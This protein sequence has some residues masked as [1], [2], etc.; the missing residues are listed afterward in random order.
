MVIKL[1]LAAVLS[2]GLIAPAGADLQDGVA[3]YVRGDFATAIREWKPLAE[4]GDPEAQFHLGEM[5]LRGRGVTQNFQE[6]ADWYTK[7]A[8]SGHSGAQ[9]VLGGLHAVGLGVPQD[10]GEAYFWLIV[11][12]IWSKSEIRQQAMTSLG[13]VAKQLTPAEKAGIARQAIA[14]WRK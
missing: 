14:Q 5:Y 12:A 11:A 6:A 8:E 10:F 2:L 1:T 4:Q 7:A 3:A 13:E 9:G